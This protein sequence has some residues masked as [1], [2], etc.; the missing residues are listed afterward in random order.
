M[1][2]SIPPIH[3]QPSS[4]QMAEP[5]PAASDT[6]EKIEQIELRAGILFCKSDCC[7]FHRRQTGMEIISQNEKLLF[8][9]LCCDKLWMLDR[10]IRITM[11]NRS[12]THCLNLKNAFSDWKELSRSW[13]RARSLSK[14]A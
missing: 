6:W 9:F 13:K 7:K 1:A 14:R 3:F 2:C 11:F 10:A 12:R 5:L 4:T 8:I